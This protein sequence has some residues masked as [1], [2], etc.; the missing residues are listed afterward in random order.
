MSERYDDPEAI[1]AFAVLD[2]LGRIEGPDETSIPEPEDDV[3]RV[4]RRLYVETTGLLPYGLEPVPVESS[5]RGRILTSIVGDLTQEVPP[6]RGDVSDVA[7]PLAAPPIAASG[8]P[9]PFRAARAAAPSRWPARFA[10]AAGVALVAGLGLWVA[11]LRSEV[12][13]SEAR[14]AWAEREWKASAESSREALVALQRSF[15]SVTAPAVTIFPLRCPTGHG[16]AANAR[17]YVYVPAN[18]QRWELAVHGLAPEPPG[19]DYQVWFL[20][21]DRPTSGGC[22]NVQNGRAIVSMP[23]RAPAGTTGVAVTVEPKGGSP[24]PTGEM[25]LVA[26]EP[27]RL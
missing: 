25:I 5:L 11:Y 13:A 27:I 17:V 24:R 20:V 26:H 19:R 15:A 23:E 4:L 22:F 18:R 7:V 10:V 12:R 16:P 3:E 14:L 6:L 21:G 1:A 2:G 8:P 9:T